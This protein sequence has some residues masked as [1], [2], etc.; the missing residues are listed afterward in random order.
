MLTKIL[1]SFQR[2]IVTPNS[3]T[4]T[5]NL[6]VDGVRDPYR[7]RLVAVFG[8]ILASSDEHYEPSASICLTSEFIRLG[9]TDAIWLK[10][11]DRHSVLLTDDRGLYSAAL[12]VGIEAYK[13]SHA[14]E[15][16]R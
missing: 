3:S 10:V 8:A 6:I 16:R 12:Q 7:S 9:L 14:R 4:E 1:S 13:F 15:L 11:L 5:S 2:L